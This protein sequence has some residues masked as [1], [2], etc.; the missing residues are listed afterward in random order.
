MKAPNA[1]DIHSTFMNG[2][3]YRFDL[4]SD[5]SV[6]SINSIVINNENN[7]QEF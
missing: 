7:Q 4:S 5:V 3:Y 2:G 1:D 6:L